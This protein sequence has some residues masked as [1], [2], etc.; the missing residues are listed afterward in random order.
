MNIRLARSETDRQI[1]DLKRW[2]NE[3]NDAEERKLRG[4]FILFR[5]ISLLPQSIFGSSPLSLRIWSMIGD[6]LERK[7]GL[8]KPDKR[9]YKCVED[10]SPDTKGGLS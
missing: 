7:F 5:V 10:A 3:P 6:W 4:E 9:G 2:M 1:F 8:P